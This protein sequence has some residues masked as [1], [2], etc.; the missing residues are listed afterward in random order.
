MKKKGW[1][2]FIAVSVFSAFSGALNCQ[3]A[4]ADCSFAAQAI[5]AKAPRCHYAAAQAK[6]ENPSR[7]ECCGK[8]RVEKAAVLSDELLL[9]REALP[10]NTLAEIK[11]FTDFYSKIQRLSF[12]PGTFTESP[13]GF[14]EQYI[15]N[16]TF[17]FRAPPQG[18][19][20]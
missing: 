7:K 6:G 11:S 20:A 14:F 16:T 12:S 18:H 3:C 17:S 1:A 5:H 15:L 8:C 19:V 4:D 13:L 9:G 2:L 10:R